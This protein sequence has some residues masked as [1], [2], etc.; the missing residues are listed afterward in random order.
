MLIVSFD[1][2]D[3]IQRQFKLSNDDIEQG[4]THDEDDGHKDSLY[5]TLWFKVS[6]ANGCDRG[7]HEVGGLNSSII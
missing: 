2:V 3:L 1:L 5:V 4:D 6:K 7:Q